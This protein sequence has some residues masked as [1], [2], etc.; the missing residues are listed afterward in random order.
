VRTDPVLRTAQ[1]WRQMPERR[2]VDGLAVVSYDAP[3]KA[4]DLRCPQQ[5]ADWTSL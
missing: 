3:P 5:R 1:P 2:V 4:D